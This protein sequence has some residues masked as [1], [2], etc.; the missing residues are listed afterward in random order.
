MTH[1]E[2]IKIVKSVKRMAETFGR[3]GNF[4]TLSLSL[5]LSSHL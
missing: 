5:S 4:V 3:S 1:R 2:N